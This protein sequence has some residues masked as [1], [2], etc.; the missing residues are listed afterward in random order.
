MV[1]GEMSGLVLARHKFQ[2]SMSVLKH[3]AARSFEHSHDMAHAPEATSAAV[4]G[5]GIMAN[6]GSQKGRAVLSWWAV[7]GCI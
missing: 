3:I 7:Q 2:W 6:G 4:D 5:D 1:Q